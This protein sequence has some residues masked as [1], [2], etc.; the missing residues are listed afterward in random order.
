MILSD[1]ET[2]S[3]ENYTDY[4]DTRQGIGIS[5][6]GYF[7]ER[8]FEGSGH[9][10]CRPRLH[11]DNL[12]Y[13]QEAPFRVESTRSR[14]LSMGY[15]RQQKLQKVSTAPEKRED[16]IDRDLHRRLS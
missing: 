7:P 13:R 2:Y 15:H 4:F 16:Q 1:E 11:R 6:T 12:K 9:F 14:R 8:H 3:L 5:L 10:F